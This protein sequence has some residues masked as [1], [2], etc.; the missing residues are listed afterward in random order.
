MITFNCPYC[1]KEIVKPVLYPEFT[2]H[3]ISCGLLAER[4]QRNF[5]CLCGFVCDGPHEHNGSPAR[6][7]IDHFDK[8]AHDWAVL[9]EHAKTLSVMESM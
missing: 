2:N 4:G 7:W 5:V 3:A 8:V 6:Q 1:D 9:I